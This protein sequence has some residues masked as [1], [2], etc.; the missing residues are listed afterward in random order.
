MVIDTEFSLSALGRS[1]EIKICE[2]T[3]YDLSLKLK[4]YEPPILCMAYATAWIE[5][6]ILNCTVV[7]IDLSALNQAAKNCVCKS[8]SERDLL[9]FLLGSRLP[10]FLY[11]PLR[12][13]QIPKNIAE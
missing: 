1:D 7:P 13:Q 5:S 8:A 12:N 4:A 11:A 9:H 3:T 2:C 6:C 10:S